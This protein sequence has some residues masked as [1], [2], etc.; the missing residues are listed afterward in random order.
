M[1]S[2][3]GACVSYAML[4]LADNT[5]GCSRRASSQAS[6]RGNIAAAFAYASDISAPRIG[7]RRLGTVGAAHRRGFM[8]GLAIGGLLAGN[9]EHTA[10]FAACAVVSAASSL[11]AISLVYFLLPESHSK[12]HRTTRRRAAQWPPDPAAEGAADPAVHR[13]RRVPG[14]PARRRSSNRSSRSGR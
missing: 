14:R 9:D 13:V 7:R 1:S 4:G 6:W 12:E 11:V 2:L 3:A 8:F 10:N 5:G